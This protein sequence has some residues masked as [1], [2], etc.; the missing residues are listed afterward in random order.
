VHRA[1]VI[2]QIEEVFVG[3]QPLNLQKRPWTKEVP[4]VQ[5]HNAPPVDACATLFDALRI[6]LLVDPRLCG[7]RLMR[8]DDTLPTNRVPYDTA[9][10]HAVAGHLAH[11]ARSVER[12]GLF[13]QSRSQGDGASELLRLRERPSWTKPRIPTIC[14]L[15]AEG[16]ARVTLISA[17]CGSNRGRLGVARGFRW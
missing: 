7:R 6:N 4:T 5:R 3:C 10:H 8:T 9:D 1:R 2:Y 16:S 15:Y 11:Q 17:T 13:T 12:T 14:G